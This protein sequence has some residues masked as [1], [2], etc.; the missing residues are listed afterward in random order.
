MRSGDQHLFATVAG[1]DD[2]IWSQYREALSQAFAALYECLFGMNARPQLC[3]A[4]RPEHRRMVSG[5]RVNSWPLL[6]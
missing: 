1:S 4:F 6:T 2:S 3:P 5:I